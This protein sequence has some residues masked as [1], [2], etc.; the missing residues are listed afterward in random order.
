MSYINKFKGRS[1]VICNASRPKA[2]RKVF[3]D[4][5]GQPLCHIC[6]DLIY[7]ADFNRQTLLA[8]ASF[9]HTYQPPKPLSKAEIAELQRANE[10][11]YQAQLQAEM[12]KANIPDD[13]ELELED[14]VPVIGGF[15][16]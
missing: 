7:L 3:N 15:S 5:F 2:A 1:C 6:K 9:V 13:P 12:A 10:A 14:E 4:V 16:W 11:A 8:A